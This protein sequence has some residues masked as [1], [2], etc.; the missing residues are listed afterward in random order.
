MKRHLRDIHKIVRKHLPVFHRYVRIAEVFQKPPIV[1][2]RWE[3]NL[4]D[5]EVHGKTNK[6]LKQKDGT[7]SCRVWYAMHRDK[8]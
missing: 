1:A 3:K 2:Y 4:A 7:C 8:I 6:E 5:T